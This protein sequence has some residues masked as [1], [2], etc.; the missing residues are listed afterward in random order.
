MS[1]ISWDSRGGYDERSSTCIDVSKLYSQGYIF[2]DTDYMN[3]TIVGKW[4]K[5]GVLIRG[6][7]F[8]GKPEFYRGGVVAD[9]DV[10]LEGFSD[11]YYYNSI[12]YHVSREMMPLQLSLKLK[13]TNYSVVFRKNL[14][15]INISGGTLQM[16]II[17]FAHNY[18]LSNVL[19]DLSSINIPSDLHWVEDFCW[20][21]SRDLT[22]TT[23]YQ[24]VFH[25]NPF[26][27]ATT[28]ASVLVRD[29]ELIPY[30]NIGDKIV[31]IS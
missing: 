18:A 10:L 21:V 11:S 2:N 22:N 24:I 6:L 1:N 19:I 28:N 16:P 14:L 9:S 26:F 3:C 15:T 12:I 27:N 31:E 23:N 8:P 4:I 13:A 25:Y 30:H 17:C 29:Y 20:N 5:G 7:V